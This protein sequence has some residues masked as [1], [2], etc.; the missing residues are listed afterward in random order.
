M[1]N[2]PA[3]AFV[4]TVEEGSAAEA[5]GLKKGDIITKV[6]GTSIDSSDTLVETLGYYQV[7]ETITIEIQESENGA[8]VS[9]ELE[10]TLQEGTVTTE[11]SETDET[12][13]EEYDGS[14]DELYDYFFGGRGRSDD[15]GL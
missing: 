2:M 8:Y 9:R 13:Y 10:V 15:P 3:G 11:E 7:G 12:P 4:Y 1:Y 14:P 5:A 6:D